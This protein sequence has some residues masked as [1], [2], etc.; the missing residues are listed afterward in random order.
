MRSLLSKITEVV[1]SLWSA[2]CARVTCSDDIVERDRG[3]RA[4]RE[5]ERRALQLGRVDAAKGDAN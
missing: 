1:H 4:T 5:N 2:C 3:G